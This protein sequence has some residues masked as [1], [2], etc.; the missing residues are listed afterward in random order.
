MT[1]R[2][3][4]RIAHEVRRDALT[5][6]LARPATADE[7]LE[8]RPTTSPATLARDL[9][10]L[11]DRGRVKVAGRDYRGAPRYQATGQEPTL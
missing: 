9:A 8:A 5:T 3:A 4:R 2:P 6:H 11:I 1:A 7:I 10:Y